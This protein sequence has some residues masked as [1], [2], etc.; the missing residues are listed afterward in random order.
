MSQKFKGWADV[1][2][3]LR[4][5]ADAQ[6]RLEIENPSVK[7]RLNKGQRASLLAVAKRIGE[8][9]VV[10]AD[11]VGMGKTR[12]A[13]EIA[14]SVVGSGGRVAIVVPPGLGDQWQKELRDGGLADVPPILRTL[15]SF[16]DVWNDDDVMNHQP[17]FKKDI[18]VISQ[19]LSRWRLGSSSD[20]WR[21]ALLR[22]LYARWRKH[23]KQWPWGYH[24]TEKRRKKSTF[25]A[26]VSIVDFAIKN[27][28]TEW[29]D[30][31]CAATDWP[32]PSKP[33]AYGK[34]GPLRTWLEQGV[35]LGLGAFD[36]IIIDEAH[37]ARDEQ[38]SLSSLLNNVLLVTTSTRRIAMTATPVELDVSQWRNTLSR[39]CSRL[40]NIAFHLICVG[41]PSIV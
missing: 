7:Q 28:N 5:Q 26:A 20:K 9:G 14:K 17:W 11:E 13:V 37:K 25:R 35:G 40:G 29:F 4:T 16:L 31:L 39:G 6:Q 36:L 33:S 10:I 22:D 30:R 21:F 12:I 24:A 3:R 19:I 32:T 8:N 27:G 23:K 2:S 34:D 1:A 38:S 15:R 41:F 18:V